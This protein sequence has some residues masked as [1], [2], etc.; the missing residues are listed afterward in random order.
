[1]ATNEPAAQQ[2]TGRSQGVNGLPNEISLAFADKLRSVLAVYRV[3]S[4]G[5]IRALSAYGLFDIFSERYPDIAVSKTHM[6]RLLNGDAIPRLDLIYAISEICS[7]E[8]AYFVVDDLGIDQA[9]RSRP[10]NIPD[11]DVK[12][13]ELVDSYEVAAAPGE[14]PRPITGYRLHQILTEQFPDVAVSKAHLYRLLNG[15]TIPS[16]RPTAAI[17]RL[18]VIL[19][20]AQIFS[21]TPAYFVDADIDVAHSGLWPRLR[22]RSTT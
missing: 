18:D 10:H 13:R 1:M 3:G 9:K 14:E 20:F 4:A 15:H 7:I 5:K 6:Y 22:P 17:P 11:F 16:R 21:I 8:P 12:L 2:P 19:A